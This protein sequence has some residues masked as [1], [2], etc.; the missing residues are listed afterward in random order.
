MNTTDTTESLDT[1]ETS[2]GHVQLDGVT[3]APLVRRLTVIAGQARGIG[4]ML[5]EGRACDD[6]LTELNALQAASR[7]V[8]METLEAF[9]LACV[10][11]SR[12]GKTP[13]AVMARIFSVVA[14]MRL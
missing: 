9:A 1:S 13:E 2:I 5:E 7:A 11:E 8:G 3:R 12:E 4:H 6:I 10:R 14:K